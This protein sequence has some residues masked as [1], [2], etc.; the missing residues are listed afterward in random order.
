MA[1]LI[2]ISWPFFFLTG[3]VPQVQT[4]PYAIFAHLVAE[5]VT[6]VSLIV[7]GAGLLQKRP[8]AA[9]AAPAALGMLLYTLINSSGYF[10]DQGEW[11]LVAMF[12]VLLILA[13]VGL[14]FLM[15]VR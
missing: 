6:A 2:V 14:R 4:E 9:R 13:L 11:P 5:I 8:W 12:A 3:Q 7:A 1:L 15:W 10:A